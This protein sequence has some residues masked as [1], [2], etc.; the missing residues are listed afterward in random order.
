MSDL[1]Q[2]LENATTEIDRRRAWLRERGEWLERELK[3][4]TLENVYRD[5]Y[6]ILRM[7]EIDDE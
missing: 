5:E 1:S 7:R 2:M 6:D 4:L 3:R